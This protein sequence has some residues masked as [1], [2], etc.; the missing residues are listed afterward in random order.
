MISFLN[1]F[2]KNEILRLCTT[3][4][5]I[6]KGNCKSFCRCSI[7]GKTLGKM[8]STSKLQGTR[9]AF[10]AANKQIITEKL[11]MSLKS[12]ILLLTPVDYLCTMN[13]NTHGGG[14]QVLK[15]L[16][17]ITGTHRRLFVTFTFFP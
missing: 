14:H 7:R 13:W 15:L 9:P 1:G 6:A 10:T 16:M 17:S 12:I 11:K 3:S 4:R 2:F 8:L 5:I